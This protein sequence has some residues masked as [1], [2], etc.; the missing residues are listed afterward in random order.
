MFTSFVIC[1][2]GRM[3]EFAIFTSSATFEGI[4]KTY[5]VVWSKGGRKQRGI[6]IKVYSGEM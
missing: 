6:W 1:I 5:V 4:N 2:L 3:P